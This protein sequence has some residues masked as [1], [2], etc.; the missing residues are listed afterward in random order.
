[1]TTRKGALVPAIQ[2]LQELGCEVT[3]NGAGSHYRVHYCG[4]YVGALSGSPSDQHGTKNSLRKIARR[5]ALLQSTGKTF[6]PGS[7]T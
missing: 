1:M 3:R 2:H 4:S 7:L 6:T 5:I